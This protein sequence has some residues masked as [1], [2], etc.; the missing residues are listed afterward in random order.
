[1]YDF[2]TD[3]HFEEIGHL[4]TRDRIADITVDGWVSEEDGR[5]ML[6]FDRRQYFCRVYKSVLVAEVKPDGTEEP[7]FHDM[8]PDFLEVEN[9][10]SYKVW[11]LAAGKETGDDGKLIVKDAESGQGHFK[12]Y[13][14][15]AAASEDVKPK[16]KKEGFIGRLFG[17]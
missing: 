11:A 2:E 1:M 17:K 12:L 15:V 16:G 13:M 7:I 9:G 14:R 3:G 10:R 4:T 5:V 8:L 6:W